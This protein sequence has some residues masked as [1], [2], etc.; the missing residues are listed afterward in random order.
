MPR[1][2]SDTF[3][4]INVNH[5]FICD[6]CRMCWMAKDLWKREDGKHVCLRCDSAVKDVTNT[7]LGRSFLEIVRP[8][9]GL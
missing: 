5:V 7:P 2:K 4:R 6:T 8:E 1:L 3:Q 9:L